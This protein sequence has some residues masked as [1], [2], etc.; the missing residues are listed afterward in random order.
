MGI[1]HA[2]KSSFAK[3]ICIYEKKAVPLR[4]ILQRG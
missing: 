2:K 1:T 4:L 3:K